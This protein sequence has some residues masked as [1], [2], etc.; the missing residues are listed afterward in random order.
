MNTKGKRNNFDKKQLIWLAVSLVALYVIIPQFGNFSHSWHRLTY[1]NWYFVGLSALSIALTIV[2]SSLTYVALSVKRLRVLE[3]M[4][5]QLANT[6]INRLL[7]AGIG[8]IG[9]NIQYLRH[10]KYGAATAASIVATNNL[11]GVAA[12]MGIFLAAIIFIHNSSILPKIHV[13]LSVLLLSLVA[14]AIAIGIITLIILL[15]RNAHRLEEGFSHYV[16]QTKFLVKPARLA[17]ALTSQMALTFIDVSAL[18]F[19]IKAVGIHLSFVDA[20]IIFTF[21]AVVRNFT[22]TPG[23]I[24]GIEA[25]LLAALVAY[26]VGG[27]EALAA[28]LLY[29]LISYWIP[30]GIGAVAFFFVSDKGLLERD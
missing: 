6:F 14:V 22:P 28:V 13:H 23:G 18:Y 5:V 16:H 19:S 12:H 29:R 26:K 27:A 24:G 21:G 2:V 3:V 30:L 20:L 9:T 17:A 10:N 8:G 7:P 11:L 15:V 25:G 1:P 4:L